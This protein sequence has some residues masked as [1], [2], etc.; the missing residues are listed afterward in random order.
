MNVSEQLADAMLRIDPEH[1]RFLDDA[2]LTNY[3]LGSIDP[4]EK[5]TIDIEEA[6]SFGL[7]RGQYIERKQVAAR[8]CP[9]RFGITD[10][11]T[12]CYQAVMKTGRAPANTPPPPDFAKYGT[13]AR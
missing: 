5:E 1:V 9:G 3:G 2:A 10:I 11:L 4:V 7:S 6:K 13:P 8:V 12:P